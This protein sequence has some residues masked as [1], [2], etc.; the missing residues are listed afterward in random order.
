[1]PPTVCSGNM[2]QSAWMI[3]RGRRLIDAPGGGKALLATVRGDDLP[4][5]HPIAVGIVDERLYAFIND[6]PKGRDLERDGRY[7][8]HSLPDP[9][10]PHEL[11][12]RG[13]AR[14]VSDPATREE[15]GAGWSFEV[16][17]SYRLFEL[18]IEHAL[19]GERASR[20]MWPPRYT[21]WK[22]VAGSA[23]V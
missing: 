7:A 2:L 12:V 13:R 10:V 8:L 20:R 17:D 5:I 11:E 23:P 6:S 9:D 19:F 15:V 18:D 16:D 3:V 1:M 21:T 22:S 14:P 4:R